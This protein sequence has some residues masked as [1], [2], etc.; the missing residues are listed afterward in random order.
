MG[1]RGSDGA[2]KL[3]TL[4]SNRYRIGCG[5]SVFALSVTYSLVNE[6]FITNSLV[7]FF[8]KA[9]KGVWEIQLTESF[10]STFNV[11]YGIGRGGGL[12][13]IPF[14]PCDEKKAKV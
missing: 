10:D 13:Y 9:L 12:A 4:Y 1:E 3:H 11:D 2:F 7:A 6:S 5:F 8:F 14:P